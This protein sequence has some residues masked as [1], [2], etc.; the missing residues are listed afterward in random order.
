M[1]TK[2]QQGG[3]TMT[4]TWSGA[5]PVAADDLIVN[6]SIQ[7]ITQALSTYAAISVESLKILA[8]SVGRIGGGGAGALQLDVDNSADSVLMCRGTSFALTY[9]GTAIDLGIGPGNEVNLDGATI[10]GDV[11][12]DGGRFT[13]ASGSTISNFYATGGQSHIMND[14][15]RGTLFRVSSGRHLVQKEFA[16]YDISGDA[17][18]TIDLDVSITV[19]AATQLNQHSGH[20]ENLHAPIPNYYG[21][22]GTLDNRKATTAH[23][24]RATVCELLGVR[25][26]ENTETVDMSNAS[27]PG[28]MNRPVSGPVPLP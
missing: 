14:G 24:L 4:G 28:G 1:T 20:I 2:I 7:P 19:D 16:T 12:M 3:V 9:G 5:N 26:N 11:T 17:V 6:S 21:T 8:G 15:N 18:V 23:E 10:S 22:G 13:S 27:S 25:V